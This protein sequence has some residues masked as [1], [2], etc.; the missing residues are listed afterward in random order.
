MR[1]FTDAKGAAYRV[2]AVYPQSPARE[3]GTVPYVTLGLEDGWLC[4]DCG[5]ERRRMVPVP[6]GWETAPDSDLI[7]LWSAAAVVPSTRQAE[8][9]AHDG[10]RGG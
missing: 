5:A 4:F 7:A 6:A 10:R 1:E 3:P 2:W 8:R 9:A